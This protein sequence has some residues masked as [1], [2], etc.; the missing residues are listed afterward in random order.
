LGIGI[1]ASIRHL[2]QNWNDQ[3]L[4]GSQPVSTDGAIPTEPK[5]K[6]VPNFGAGLYYYTPV[7]FV[8]FSVPRLVN[9]NIDF[10]DLGGKLSREVQHF[11]LMAG[12]NYTI[13]EG[14]VMTPQALV[15][16]VKAAPL[17]ADVNVNFEFQKRFLAGLTYRTGSGKVSAGGESMDLIAGIYA[18]QS[19]YFGLSYDIGLTKIRKYNNGSVEATI[20]YWLNAPE[21]TKI[22]DAR[23]F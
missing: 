18:T 16:Y 22:N 4:I 20:R 11:Y 21:G 7:Y 3:R 14:V 9:N 19:L 12:F 17:S 10:D 6:V 2:R 1:K 23:N 15:K 8:G 13:A 5:T